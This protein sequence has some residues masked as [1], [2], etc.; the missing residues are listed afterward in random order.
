MLARRLRGRFSCQIR[1]QN[2]SPGWPIPSAS[3][4]AV[5]SSRPSKT[6]RGSSPI[7]M[8]ALGLAPP[9][10]SMR[11]PVLPY[12]PMIPNSSPTRRRSASSSSRRCSPHLL[13]AP[14]EEWIPILRRRCWS[15]PSFTDSPTARSDRSSQLPE[16]PRGMNSF[17]PP[18][19]RFCRVGNT[20]LAPCRVSSHCSGR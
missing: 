5:R 6:I 11:S 19:G 12:P 16:A 17:A 14:H 4:T 1:G 3:R 2:N 7:W 13:A 9:R 18:R 10:Y 8:I 15:G 20:S